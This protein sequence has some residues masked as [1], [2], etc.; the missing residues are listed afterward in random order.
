MRHEGRMSHIAVFLNAGKHS[1]TALRR[2]MCVW[3]A[4]MR[5]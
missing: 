5:H 2:N 1:E 4:E 3:D